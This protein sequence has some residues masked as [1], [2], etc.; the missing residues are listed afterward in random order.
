MTEDSTNSQGLILRV[1]PTIKHTITQFEKCFRDATSSTVV[2]LHIVCT[3]IC[4]VMSVVVAPVKGLLL[5]FFMKVYRHDAT[6]ID[7]P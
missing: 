7:L 5:A 6:H 4:S 2:R 3:I 1:Y